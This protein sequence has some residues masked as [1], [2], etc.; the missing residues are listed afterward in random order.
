MAPP[1][2]GSVPTPPEPAVAATPR[3]DVA[4]LTVIRPPILVAAILAL[5]LLVVFAELPGRPLILHTLQ[6]LAH[7]GV[8]GM[9]AVGVLVLARQRTAGRRGP[10]FDYLVAFL[11]AVAI[12]GATEIGQLFT[13][14]DP[15]LRDVGLDARGAA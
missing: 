11:V 8:F 7:P 4:R 3:F 2:P 15:S 5:A 6:K 9:I 13:H 14:R 1:A 10:W 12:G